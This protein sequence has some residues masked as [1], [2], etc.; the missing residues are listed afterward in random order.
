[1]TKSLP[2][3]SGVFAAALTPLT[4][5]LAPDIVRLAGHCRWLLGHGCDGLAVGPVMGS[6]IHLIDREDDG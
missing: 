5:D 6:F 3:A 4:A 2:P 1:M